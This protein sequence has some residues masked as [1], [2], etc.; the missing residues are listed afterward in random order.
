MICTL[1]KGPANLQSPL[2]PKPVKRRDKGGRR[3]RYNRK[4]REP[5]GKTRPALLA[6]P[7]PRYM[8]RQHLS[9]RAFSFNRLKINQFTW[10][11][12]LE[13]GFSG[14]MVTRY[15]CKLCAPWHVVH[16]VLY[17]ICLLKAVVL[18]RSVYIQICTHILQILLEDKFNTAI[19]CTLVP[20][21][22]LL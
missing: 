6:D 5:T 10:F 19:F 14:R 20:I 17:R 4:Q 9:R 18:I 11:I 2:K 3:E 12:T 15:V 16:T 1:E 21:F 7:P 8:T 22:N 13:N